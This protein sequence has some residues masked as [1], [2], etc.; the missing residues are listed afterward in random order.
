[1]PKSAERKIERQGGASKYRTVKKDGHT[2]T[3]AITKKEGPKGGRTVC[4]R[5]H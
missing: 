1:M 5:K 3:C 2:F 4:W